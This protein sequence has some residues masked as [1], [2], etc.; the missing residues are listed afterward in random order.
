MLAGL[1][2]HIDPIMDAGC[3]WGKAPCHAHFD[4]RQKNSK[5]DPVHTAGKAERSIMYEVN[6][7]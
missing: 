4:V 5:C 7:M 3:L 2:E 6:V 1:L